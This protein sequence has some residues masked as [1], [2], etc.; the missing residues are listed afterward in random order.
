LDIYKR[1]QSFLVLLLTLPL[2]LEFPEFLELV[3]DGSRLDCVLPL[4]GVKG[5]N[6][7]E[8]VLEDFI[9]LS[10]LE[11]L[12]PLERVGSV[13]FSLSILKRSSFKS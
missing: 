8:V 1:E 10:L 5:V 3:V 6:L 7:Y 12:E 4:P 13:L 9:L 2:R 11:L